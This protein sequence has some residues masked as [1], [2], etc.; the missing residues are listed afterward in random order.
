MRY[1]SKH[2]KVKFIS[3][4]NTRAYRKNYRVT[5]EVEGE[6]NIEQPNV[7]FVEVLKKAR[8]KY[9]G[10]QPNRNLKLTKDE[11]WKKNEQRTQHS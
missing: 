11:E 2:W 1:G 6:T 8:K 10:M 3:S 9:I 7:T 5:D 4:T